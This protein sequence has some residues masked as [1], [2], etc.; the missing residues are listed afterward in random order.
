M[1]LPF[2]ALA[3]GLLLLF[4]G[5]G[6]HCAQHVVSTRRP[7]VS[8]HQCCW[9]MGLLLGSSFQIVHLSVKRGSRPPKPDPAASH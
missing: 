7:E 1:S 9:V 3:V 2:S 5:F 6:A 8:Q 4:L